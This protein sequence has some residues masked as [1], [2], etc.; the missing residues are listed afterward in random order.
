MI[1]FLLGFLSIYGSVHVYAFLKVRSA[2]SLGTGAGIILGVFMAAMTCA[3][4]IVRI[5]ERHEYEVSAR[6]FSCIGY[7][8]MGVLFLFFSL[9]LLMDIY[10]IFVNTAGLIMHMDIAQIMPSARLAFLLPLILALCISLYGYFE[11]LDIRA[12]KIEIVS[13]KI[14]E[15]MGRLRIV[16]ISDVHLG[17]IVRQHR[18]SRI[19]EVITEATPDILVSTGDLVDGQINGL[20]SLAQ[21]LKEVEPRYGKYAVTGNHEFYAGLAQALQITRDAGFSVLRGE[22]VTVRDLITIAGVDDPTGTRFGLSTGA[23]EKEL[24]AGLPGDTYTVLLKHLP[25]V[26][27][28]TQGMYDL[29]LSGHTHRGQIFPFRLVIGLFFSHVAGLYDLPGG[30]HLYVSRG[31]GTWGPPMRFLSP[32]EVT[33][34]DIMHDKHP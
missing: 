6:M 13:S 32:P 33:V 11:A 3:P 9:S 21:S 31:T 29:Q 7:T 19:I 22:A 34:I 15:S 18:L 14:P 23:S 28:D 17:L 24:L 1:L 10:R 4:I 8:W 2:F 30:A 26:C 20:S 12:E 27:K 5:L 25:L 16:Q